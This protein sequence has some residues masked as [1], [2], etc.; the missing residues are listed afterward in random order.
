M[1]KESEGMSDEEIILAILN[2]KFA[3]YSQARNNAPDPEMGNLSPD[4]VHRLIYTEWE[5]PQ[6]PI[7]I[8][9]DLPVE[10]CETSIFF[11]ATRQFL[12][13]V[14][15]A[16]G[17]KATATGNLPRKF[18]AEM[19]DVFLDPEEKK[20]LLRINKVVNET[21]LFDLHVSRVV[22]EEAGL[23]GNYKG[24]FVLRKKYQHLLEPEK[25]GELFRHLFITY[26]QKFNLGYADG[27][28]I[29]THSLQGSIA[30]T[31]NC[32][33]KLPD[34]WQPIKPLPKKILL[35][36]IRAE[37]E[38]SIRDLPY[39]EIHNVLELRL[40]RHL[41]QWGLLEIQ[42]QKGNYVEEAQAIRIFPFFGK[43]ISFAI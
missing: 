28:S 12:L 9:R 17:I 15:D 22:C 29:E 2:E 20:T 19:I 7:Q 27:I 34:S 25:A 31:L 36:A 38:L 18:V 21:D 35:P 1:F 4:Q 43:V 24:K 10:A 11:R 30:Y 26:F 23:I 40:F 42:Y 33:Q 16:G 14:R 41:S 39:T 6:C 32:L 8:N 13:S 5:S 37:L 3:Q